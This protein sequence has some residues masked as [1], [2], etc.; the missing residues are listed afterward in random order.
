[1][2]TTNLNFRQPV[3]K[4]PIKVTSSALTVT[5]PS[6]VFMLIYHHTV[7]AFNPCFNKKLMWLALILCMSCCFTVSG[8]YTRSFCEFIGE[9]Q[10]KISITKKLSY[11][12]LQ[13]NVKMQ[14]KIQK[15]TYCW[16]MTS[17]SFQGTVSSF[18]RWGGPKQNCLCQTYSAFCVP[19]I[20]Q[21]SSFLTESSNIIRMAFFETQRVLWTEQHLFPVCRL[22]FS[23]QHDSSSNEDHHHQHHHPLNS[24]FSS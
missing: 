22:N 10:Q 9:P 11:F 3:P 19:K 24:Y 18:Y 7:L 16:K 21:I 1:M 8:A 17:L 4:E 15:T 12:Y 23:V 14:L 6:Y 13:E 20:I 2:L 5:H